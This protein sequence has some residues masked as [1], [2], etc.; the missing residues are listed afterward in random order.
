MITNV[1]S[2]NQS[3]GVTAGSIRADQ[4]AEDRPKWKKI[5]IGVAAVLSALAAIAGVL[6]YVGWRPWN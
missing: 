1:T 6:N 5:L 2:N 4:P 3:G